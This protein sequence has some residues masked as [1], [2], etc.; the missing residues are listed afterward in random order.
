MSSEVNGKPEAKDLVANRVRAFI[1]TDGVE[2]KITVDPN[3]TA[4]QTFR[5]GHSENLT[6]SEALEL[7]EQPGIKIVK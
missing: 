1:S 7:L 2:S 3:G 6:P 5:V 4:V